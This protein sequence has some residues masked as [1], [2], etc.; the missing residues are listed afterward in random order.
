MR[1]F[2][3]R[4]SWLVYLVFMPIAT[5]VAGVILWGLPTGIFEF[6]SS[7]AISHY[8]VLCIVVFLTVVFSG[9]VLKGIMMAFGAGYYYAVD[10]EGIIVTMCYKEKKFLFSDLKSIHS[11]DETQVG[12]LLYRINKNILDFN[13]FF[14]LGKQVKLN[15]E[16]FLLG[17]YSGIALP[18]A[19]TVTSIG[20]NS[21][22]S[23]T[24]YIAA[25]K[26]NPQ[27]GEYILVTT[28]NG[29]LLIL[30]PLRANEFYDLLP[31]K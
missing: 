12:D 26:I 9:T 27:K 29:E 6:N 8:I 3:F 11:L 17:K 10:S 25:L 23:F 7:S 28:K 2:Y 21:T 1:K 24:T 16:L 13:V 31:K 22:V 18:T 20:I 30:T 5:I 19:E 14:D 4:Y 15:K